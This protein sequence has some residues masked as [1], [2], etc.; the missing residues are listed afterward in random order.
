M[1]VAQHRGLALHVRPWKDGQKPNPC[2]R[3]PVFPAV[4]WLV[5][6]RPSVGRD[7]RAGA[8]R[9]PRK[10]GIRHLFTSIPTVTLMVHNK[11]SFQKPDSP[12]GG[13]GGHAVFGLVMSI[14]PSCSRHGRSLL[15]G[16]LCSRGRLGPQPPAGLTALDIRT[17][18]TPGLPAGQEH[19][20]LRGRGALCPV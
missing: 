3:S 16:S 4:W 11:D 18:G 7:S 15:A 14:S 17:G 13:L 12:H 19:Q 5:S 6:E 10:T 2:T 1:L 8:S 20:A 9:G